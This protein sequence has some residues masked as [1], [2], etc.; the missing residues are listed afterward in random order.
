MI[1]LDLALSPI[2]LH[3]SI[4]NSLYRFIPA[5]LNTFK[6]KL[7]RQVEIPLILKSKATDSSHQKKPVEDLIALANYVENI[8]S[9]PTSIAVDVIKELGEP[10]AAPSRT[11]QVL[12]YMLWNSKGSVSQKNRHKKKFPMNQV[13]LKNSVSD[14]FT[15][16]S[17]W[18]G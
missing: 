11:P 14:P 13:K 15:T 1:F 4:A 8:L 5:Y 17:H 18:M 3:P 2:Y 7:S 10:R 12:D 9:M 16:P 6:N